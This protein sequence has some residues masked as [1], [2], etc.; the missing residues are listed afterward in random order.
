MLYKVI[1]GRHFVGKKEYVKGDVIE[2]DD[3]LMERFPNKFERILTA[4]AVKEVEVPAE[5]QTAFEEEAAASEVEIPAK[6][7]EPVLGEDV[8][9]EFPL[10]VD[11]D[12]RVWAVK[13]GSATR[14]IPAE[15]EPPYTQLS[16]AP[17]T[18]NGLMKL[19]N[20]EN[21]EE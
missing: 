19:L 6:K 16:E 7:E 17:L 13:Q 4:S 5:V 15:T 21:N 9:V 14:Y 20:A 11:R 2:G 12:I 10:A 3:M 8:T 18:K 1:N